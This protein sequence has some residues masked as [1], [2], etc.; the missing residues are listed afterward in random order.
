MALMKPTHAGDCPVDALTRIHSIGLE[1][2]ANQTPNAR[3]MGY[4]GIQQRLLW[5]ILSQPELIEQAQAT[6]ARYCAAEGVTFAQAIIQRAGSAP[7]YRRA[8]KSAQREGKL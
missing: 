1:W 5:I 7:Q 3:Q 8:V 6:L 4:E 2:F